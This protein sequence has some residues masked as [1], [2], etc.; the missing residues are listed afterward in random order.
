MTTKPIPASPPS[1]IRGEAIGLLHIRHAEIKFAHDILVNGADTF[2]T[3]NDPE[4]AEL[5]PLLQKKLTQSRV[6]LQIIEKL[7]RT[8]DQEDSRTTCRSHSTPQSAAECYLVQGFLD[9][10]SKVR[11]WH[12]TLIDLLPAIASDSP[13][14]T[15]QYTTQAL[16][17][18]WDSIFKARSQLEELEALIR[19]FEEDNHGTDNFIMLGQLIQQAVQ[20]PAGGDGENKNGT[21]KSE[22]GQ[23]KRRLGQNFGGK[24]EK[25]DHV[26]R[27]QGGE[28]VR[29]D[30]KHEGVGDS[31]KKTL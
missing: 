8:L 14:K 5:F 11:A 28:G 27:G 2:D 30:A 4:D 22:K 17:D 29:A 9:A 10:H 21:K 13:N 19:T 26:S 23:G 7:S 20:V 3:T 6:R 16:A 31:C 12:D 25:N 1:T 15:D 24:T 18:V